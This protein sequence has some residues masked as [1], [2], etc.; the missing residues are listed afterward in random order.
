[1]C[2]ISRKSR[3]NLLFGLLQR[4]DLVE[5]IGTGV[6]R[7]RDE[8]KSYNLTGPEFDISDDWFTIVFK[9]PQLQRLGE[10]VGE[11]VGERLTENQKKIVDLIRTDKYITFKE[12]SEKIKMSEKNIYF[13]IEKLKKK[14]LLKRIGPAKGGY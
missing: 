8:M 10:K 9:R 2:Y 7:M 1:M 14:D 3:N 5:N 6:R 12:L 11:K 4:I 13:N